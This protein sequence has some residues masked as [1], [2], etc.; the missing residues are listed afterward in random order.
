MTQHFVLYFF[1][2]IRYQP[3]KVFQ[4]NIYQS[5][6]IIVTDVLLQ[7]LTRTLAIR[8]GTVNQRD[9]LPPQTQIWSRSAQK[10]LAD[11]AS[12]KILS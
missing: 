12:M 3:S 6:R 9:E 1:I 4:F 10:W 5:K 8:L 7:Q 11:L 2:P